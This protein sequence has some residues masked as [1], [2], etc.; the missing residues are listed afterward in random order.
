MSTVLR[1]KLDEMNDVEEQV[2][3]STGIHPFTPDLENK[4]ISS[5][6]TVLDIVNNEYVTD[7]VLTRNAE[8]VS[9]AFAEDGDDLIMAVEAGVSDKETGTAGAIEESAKKYDL[10]SAEFIDDDVE[11]IEDEE[12]TE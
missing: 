12:F 1:E 4:V 11:I 9:L 6:S 10:K 2:M 8:I 3:R 7:E 5:L